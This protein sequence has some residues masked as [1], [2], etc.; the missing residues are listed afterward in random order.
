MRAANQ[1]SSALTII[2]T[3]GH[4]H[5][6]LRR[7]GP[8]LVKLLQSGLHHVDIAGAVQRLEVGDKLHTLDHTTA[9]HLEHLQDGAGRPDAHTERIPVAELRGGHLLLLVAPRLDR[10][11]GIAPLGGLLEPLRVRR[12]L[13]TRGQL[14]DKFVIAP[15]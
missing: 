14:F 15:S 8:V 7:R 12:L 6:D 1:C 11:N 3:Q 9:P 4:R 13:H 10:P 5:V 2:V